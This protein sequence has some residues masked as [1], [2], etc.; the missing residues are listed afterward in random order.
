MNLPDV[1]PLDHPIQLLV[2][3]LITLAFAWPVE[4]ILRSVANS[5]EIPRPAKIPEAKWKQLTTIPGPHGGRWIG[6]VERLLFFLLLIAGVPELGVAWLAFKVAS[7]WEAWNNVYKIPDT[8]TDATQFEF[9]LARTRWGSRT[10]QRSL[11]GTAANIVAA[12]PGVGFFYLSVSV[13]LCPFL[14]SA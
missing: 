7:K 12:L 4:A 5:V 11:I 1:Q 14:V 9:L 13:K 6:H 8:L 10:L 3:L 2:A